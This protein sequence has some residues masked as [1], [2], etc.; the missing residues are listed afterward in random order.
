MAKYVDRP[1]SSGAS[2]SAGSVASDPAFASKCPALWEYL[3]LAVWEDGSVRELS[4]LILM[5][6]EGRWKACLSD[7]A[8]DRTAWRTADT[9]AGLL[10]AL[11]AGL[12][13]GGL[14]WRR[15]K[16][17]PGRRGR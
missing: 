10:E 13:G 6:E 7:K 5:V 16:A 14:D 1:A 4:T 12:A 15:P 2:P 3:T 11:E 9:L 8:N 17:P